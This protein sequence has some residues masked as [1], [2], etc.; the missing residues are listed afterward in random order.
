MMTYVL[1][2][3]HHVS[4]SKTE[5]RPL[6]KESKNEHKSSIRPSKAWGVYAS[7]SVIADFALYHGGKLQY[8]LSNNTLVGLT[9]LMGSQ[10]VQLHD[11]SGLQL[12]GTNDGLYYAANFS[13]FISPSF[14]FNLGLGERRA[15]MMTSITNTSENSHHTANTLLKSYV[16]SLFVGNDWDLGHGLGVQ[17]DWIGVICPF[18][19]SMTI[20]ESF[21]GNMSSTSSNSDIMVETFGSLKDA[22]TLTL[23]VI[24]VGYEF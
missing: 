22:V 11:S 18:Y 3:F 1:S 23:G 2:M 15:K 9:L 19:G 13:F 16:T 17:V 24:S 20:D 21:S 10:D 14:Y 7:Y 8:K 5:E 6:A 4:Y 12:K